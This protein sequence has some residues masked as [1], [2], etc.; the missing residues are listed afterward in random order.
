M[1]YFLVTGEK[2]GDQHAGKLIRAI[3]DND[4]KAVFK[5]VGG[6]SSS[7]AGM[8]LLFH[9]QGIAVMGFFEVILKAIRLKKWLGQ[10]KRNLIVFNPDL[11]ILIDSGG[12]NLPLA[13]FATKRGYKVLYFIPPKV[14]AWGSWRARRLIKST[15]RIVVSLPFEVELFDRLGVKTDYMGSPVANYLELATISG[16]ETNTEHIALLPGSRRQEIKY[17][18]PLMIKVAKSLPSWK[19]VVVA[20]RELE[21]TYTKSALPENVIIS[22][23]T[24]SSILKTSRAAIVASGTATLEACLLNVP[25]VVVYKTHPLNYLVAR[26]LIKTRFISLVNLMLNKQVV[27]ELIQGEANPEKL[28][29]ELSRLITDEGYRNNVIAN[30]RKVITQLGNMNAY[31][32]TANLVKGM[33]A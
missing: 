25:Q 12:F 18:L 29:Q 7:D 6:D 21:E 23:E 11:V 19:F 28:K 14:W 5:G 27:K 30:Y 3:K 1:K 24:A 2:S 26:V 20:V 16:L 10:C 17:H 33:V 4:K 9:N 31:Q 15:N 8:K 22:Y 32:A 13:Q